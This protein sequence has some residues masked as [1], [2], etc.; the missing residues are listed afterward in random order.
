[1]HSGSRAIYFLMALVAAMAEFVSA[2]FGHAPA[3]PAGLAEAT[4]TEVGEPSAIV[5]AECAAPE[6]KSTAAAVATSQNFSVNPMEMRITAYPPLLRVIANAGADS[7]QMASLA[8][9]N[10]RQLLFVKITLG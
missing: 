2:A 10:E 4:V 7:R 5:V 3:D 9:A 1:M 8:D 6:V